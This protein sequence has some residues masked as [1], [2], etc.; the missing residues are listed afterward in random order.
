MPPASTFNS[1]LSLVKNFFVPSFLSFP[2]ACSLLLATLGAREAQGCASCGCGL[3]SGWDTY[4]YSTEPGFK[5]DAIYSYINQSQLRTGTHRISPSQVP[6]GQ[7]LEKSTRTS[8]ETLGLSYDINADWGL[9]LQVPIISREHSTFGD[10]HVSFDRSSVSSIGD[11]KMLG[12]YQG[13]LADHSLGVELGLKLPTGKFNQTFESGDALDRG[14]QA[15]SGTTDL[16][17]GVYY[18]GALS[19]DWGYFAEA[20]VQTALNSRQDYRPGTAENLTAGFRYMGFGRIMPQLQINGRIASRD[21]GAESDN[22]D[23]GGSLLYISPGVS[24]TL[25]KTASA[26]GFVQ[27]PVYQNVNGYQLAP[28]WILTMGIRIAF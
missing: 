26:Y 20:T 22:F 18:F 25:T 19:P 13:F 2:L 7:E 28:S 27:I 15:G 14:L 10:D 21:T 24:V 11:V 12:H 6:L 23:S 17:A 9:N 1:I 16:V 8:T 4:G 5:L 3:G